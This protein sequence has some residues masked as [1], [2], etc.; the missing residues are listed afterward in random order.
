MGATFGQPKGTLKPDTNTFRKKG[1]GTIVL[2]EGKIKFGR[3]I[4]LN[5]TFS[6]KIY[7]LR[8]L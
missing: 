5:V 6:T 4:I 1:T 7:I 8:E 3:S 2:P